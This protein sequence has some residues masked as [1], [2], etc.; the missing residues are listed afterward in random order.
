MVKEKKVAKHVVSTHSKCNAF[1]F[2][3]MVRKIKPF[4]PIDESEHSFLFTIYNRFFTW[5][6]GA[7]HARQ[8]DAYKHLIKP[9]NA[10]NF[11]IV[12]TAMGS[13]CMFIYVS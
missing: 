2:M 1:P 4:F 11:L 6:Y 13:C 12:G 5:K 7:L 9:T 8:G 10:C 3:N